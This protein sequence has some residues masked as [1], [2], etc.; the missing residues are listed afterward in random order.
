M[1]TFLVESIVELPDIA[2][3]IRHLYL[4]N[5]KIVAV[6]GEMGAGKTTLIK[7]FCKLL[8]CSSLV[9]SPTFTI[10][11]E[12]E[13]GLYGNIYHIDL[14]RI[15]D[16]KEL[17]GLS[18]YDYFDSGCYCFIEWPEICELYLPPETLRIKIEIQG[19]T[20]NIT[21]GI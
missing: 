11:N 17:S 13:T 8:D 9:T 18:L 7:E 3:K 19:N 21:V 4:I 5:P 14:Y 12:Y 10:I 1:K 16:G 2:N 6:Y 15:K 20:R